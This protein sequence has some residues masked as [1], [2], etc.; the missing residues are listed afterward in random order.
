MSHIAA[1]LSTT[2][3]LATQSVANFAPPATAHEVLAAPPAKRTI[4]FSGHEWEVTEGFGAP[5]ATDWSSQNVWVDAQGQLHL[6]L[7]YRDGKWQGA[8]IMSKNKLGFG[9]YQFQV[10]GPLD[11]LD[12]NVV[13]GIFNY[14]GNNPN[15]FGT[16]EIDIE[17]G[18]WGYDN[19]PPGS[20]TIWPNSPKLKNRTKP[21]SF[22]LKGLES[23]HRFRWTRRFVYYQSLNGHRN[24]SNEQ[25]ASWWFQP[26][27]TTARTY[28][29]QQPLNLYIN[30]WAYK[31]RPP[32]DGKECEII[33]KSFTFTPG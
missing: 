19:V 28:I 12:P 25:L 32:K 11:R 16:N 7:T 23:T 30:L 15:V 26:T 1:L 33:I 22:K 18:K 20:Y 2:I 29:P 31:G 21:F 3:L 13:F 14:E 10:T 4:M 27:T 6:K 24:D 17:F 9:S 8:Q 5:H